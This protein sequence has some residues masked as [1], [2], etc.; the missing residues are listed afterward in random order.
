[1]PGCLLT[2]D[3]SL[4]RFRKEAREERLG[5]SVSPVERAFNLALSNFVFVVI[6]IVGLIAATIACLPILLLHKIAFTI[7]ATCASREEI[8]WSV[9]SYA[10]IVYLDQKSSLTERRLVSI[11][12]QS[13]APHTEVG[14]SQY[15]KH[16]I[17]PNFKKLNPKKRL[18]GTSV[19]KVYS[20]SRSS[21]RIFTL[22]KAHTMHK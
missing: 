14:T 22:T 16:C 4:L 8:D 10:G 1:M 5:S 11:S 13:S 19:H 7:F 3:S 21:V 18:T 12:G 2:R 6:L 17:T 20:Q 15:E 9:Q